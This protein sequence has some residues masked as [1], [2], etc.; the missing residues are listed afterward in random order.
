M[1]IDVF[2]TQ[3]HYYSQEHEW[4]GKEIV[5]PFQQHWKEEILPSWLP[6]ERQNVR[7]W[8]LKPTAIESTHCPV[9][10]YPK[11]IAIWLSELKTENMDFL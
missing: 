5:E 7:Q 6:R 11:A 8:N 1:S 4:E 3:V 10:Y 2:Y 9:P